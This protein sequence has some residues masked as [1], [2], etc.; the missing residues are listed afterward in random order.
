[1]V[2]FSHTIF[3]L[4]F[5]VVGLLLPLRGLPPWVTT[6]W[7]LAAMVG[8]RTAAMAFN[9]LV[10]ARFD[11]LNPRTASRAIPAG[12]LS[13]RVVAVGFAAAVALFLLACAS[14][15]PLCLA[16]SPVTLVLLCG[17]S[18]AKRFT[19]LSH[20]VLGAALGLSPLGAYLAVTGSFDAGWTAP[21]LLGLAVLFWV[22]GFDVIYACQDEAV[23]RSLG[24]HSLPARVGAARALRIA[25]GFH[26]LTVILLILFGL[27]A[28]LGWAYGA[29]VA[30]ATVLL[31]YEHR[32]V[33]PG[34]LERVN[35]AFFHLNA[36][37]SLLVLGGVLMGLRSPA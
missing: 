37:I 10:D 22:A 29:A 26:V 12:T 21:A 35:T 11:A 7:V 9:R 13:R 17:Y 16:L 14:L 8:A 32:L 15:N 33:S 27:R 30:L 24:L 19:S 28:E 20:L 5:A 36:I 18:M 3:A 34:N 25:A 23:D 4:P 2:K 1:M 31:I 6:V